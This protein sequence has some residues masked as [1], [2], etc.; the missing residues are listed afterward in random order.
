M[1]ASLR[2][3]DLVL[4]ESLDLELSQGFNTL[5]GETGAGK[6]IL[7]EA[8]GLAL[9]SRGK[10]NLVRAGARAAEVEALFD[11]TDD[12]AVKQRLVDAGW[13]VADELLVRRYIPVEGRSRCYVNGHPVPLAML[14]SLAKGLAELSSQHEHHTLAD[15]STHLF[16]LDA[17]A[18]LISQR[19][20]VSG[21]YT[22]VI[23]TMKE[24]DRL[25]ALEA[26]HAQREELLR[27]QLDQLKGLDPRPGEEEELRKEREVVRSATK[28]LEVA[29]R[30]EESLYSDEGAACEA[31]SRIALQLREAASV[32]PNLS[33]L[34]DQLTEALAL[35]EDVA[36]QLRRYVDAFDA[37]PGRLDAIEDRLAMYTKVRGM[38]GPGGQDLS[39]RLQEIEGA[40]LELD[41]HDELVVQ[42]RSA[43]D[44]AIATAGEVATVLSS[45]RRAA[46]RNLA[47]AFGRE[48][49][50]LGMGQAKIEV[51]VEPAKGGEPSINGARLTETGV[52]KVEFLIAP[53][54]GEPA[55]PLQSI[56]SGGELSRAALALKRA[57]AGVG[58]VGTYV[59]DE[60]DAGI[61]GVIADMVGRKLRE[62]SSQHQVLCVTHLPQVAALADAHFKVTKRERSK[63]T[64]TEIKRLDHDGRVEEIAAM[65]SGSK[66]TPRSRAAAAELIGAGEVTRP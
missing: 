55:A 53:N 64:V 2:V 13:E 7:V 44:A 56:A 1:L 60:A 57:L 49:S 27:Y 35:V 31:I 37:D 33:P 18:S 16:S 3:R 8:I 45:K 43:R 20:N 50:D 23:E 10:V 19:S 24:L 34:G 66:V 52:D 26:E 58:P 63:R 21:A 54:P 29:R 15:A 51:R 40:I 5:T 25:E 65:I 32:D 30:G 39:T 9:G 62:V 41:N 61:S 46:A 6:S 11:I 12:D 36:D 4:I 42:A 47:R 38:L 48:L 14:A 28:L 17:F 22:E 59:F